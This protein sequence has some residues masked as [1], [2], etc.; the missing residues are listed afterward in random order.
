VE[1]MKKASSLTYRR[2]C[3]S[4]WRQLKKKSEGPTKQRKRISLTGEM[5][6]WQSELKAMT[7]LQSGSVVLLCDIPAFDLLSRGSCCRN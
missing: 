1:A 7:A 3:L 6:Y 5:M 2:T 4:G